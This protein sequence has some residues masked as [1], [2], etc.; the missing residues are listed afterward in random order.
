MLNSPD[1]GRQVAA[2]M[3][4]WQMLATALVA[5][6]WLFSGPQAALAAALGGGIVTLGNWQASRL[7]LRS[8][9]PGAGLALAGVL[10]GTALKWVLVLV[11]AWLAVAV[12]R[13]PATALLSGV[14]VAVLAQVV[15]VLRR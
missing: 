8:Q 2:R 11:V 15:S 9:A 13:L 4:Y 1:Q 5:V 6:S 12:L 10:L 3:V 7:A 14:V